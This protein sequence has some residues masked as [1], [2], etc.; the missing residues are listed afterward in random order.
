LRPFDPAKTDTGGFELAPFLTDFLA[1][2][3]GHRGKKVFEA[4]VAVV[5]ADAVLSVMR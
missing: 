4:G 5:L 3:V 1:L 2:V